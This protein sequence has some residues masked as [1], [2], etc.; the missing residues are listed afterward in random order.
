MS[1]VEMVVDIQGE[2]RDKVEGDPLNISPRRT[3]Y[4][5]S[6]RYDTSQ[7]MQ[8]N[9]WVHIHVIIYSVH[10]HVHAIR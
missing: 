6:S 4:H 8:C 9:L 10:V 3:G 7:A 5:M 2:G 1:R